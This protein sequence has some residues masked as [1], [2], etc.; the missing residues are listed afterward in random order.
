MYQILIG[1][2]TFVGSPIANCN[3]HKS[4]DDESI[5]Y[6]EL[7]KLILEGLKANVELMVDTTV[8]D[9][10]ATTPLQTV[11]DLICLQYVLA[12]QKID[13]SVTKVNE[14]VIDSSMNLLVKVIAPVKDSFGINKAIDFPFMDSADMGDVLKETA[15]AFDLF[16]PSIF[17]N[18]PISELLV[19]LPSLEDSGLS[20]RELIDEANEILNAMG[21]KIQS[22]FFNEQ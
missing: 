10:L 17:I 3:Y 8:I 7:T 16:N 20:N 6:E 5:N 21:F 14:T 19:Q 22:Y 9:S 11:Y 1:Q 18:S 15:N 4:I 12:Q 13:L 2:T